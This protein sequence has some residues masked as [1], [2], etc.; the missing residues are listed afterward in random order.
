MGTNP[1]NFWTRLRDVIPIV[2]L[3]AAFGVGAFASMTQSRT[4]QLDAK[5][6]VAKITARSDL[7]SAVRVRTVQM[8][9]MERRIQIL[10]QIARENAETFK[11]LEKGQ[12]VIVANISYQS[13][14]IAS[15]EKKLD[16]RDRARP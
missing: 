15:I 8:E 2:F 4:E 16:D 7:D 10:E 9:S 14:A 13:S 1:P 12:A 11:A 3:S 6:E 5:I